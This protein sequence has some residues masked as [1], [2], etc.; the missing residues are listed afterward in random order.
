MYSP[1]YMWQHLQHFVRTLQNKPS[2]S[3]TDFSDSDSF[4]ALSKVTAPEIVDRED[5]PD[6]VYL[7]QTRSGTESDILS[8][9]SEVAAPKP[10]QQKHSTDL[11][12]PSLEGNISTFQRGIVRDD[13][14]IL[15]Q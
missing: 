3:P 4:V 8:H 9:L 5:E 11:R 7:E 1:S 10:V 15:P 13:I 6:H 2:E 14:I 12:H